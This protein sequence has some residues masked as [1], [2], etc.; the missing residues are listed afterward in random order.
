MVGQLESKL[1]EDFCLVF[2]V[3][4]DQDSRDVGQPVNDG[5]DLCLAQASRRRNGE[6]GELVSGFLSF[7]LGDPRRD[8]PGVGPGVKG[9]AV[10]R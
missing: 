10:P 8:D 3:R 5:P 1:T 7:G 9:G 6:R 4:V 2:G